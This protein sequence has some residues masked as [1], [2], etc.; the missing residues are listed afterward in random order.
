MRS[1]FCTGRELAVE[2]DAMNDDKVSGA[3]VDILESLN[4]DQRRV[5]LKI[6]FIGP[7]CFTQAVG[8]YVHA[9]ETP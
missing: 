8:H 2:V 7:Q 1:G 9:A 5:L 6:A 3:L 4:D